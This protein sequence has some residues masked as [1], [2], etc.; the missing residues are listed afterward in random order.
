MYIY[1]CICMCTYVCVYV[2]IYIY[3]LIVTILMIIIYTKILNELRKKHAVATPENRWRSG[4]DK[5]RTPLPRCLPDS[6]SGAFLQ[7]IITNDTLN[8]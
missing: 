4:P 3:I 8:I 1:T 2:C 7:M 6:W 5:D